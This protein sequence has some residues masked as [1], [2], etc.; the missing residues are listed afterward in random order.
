MVTSKRDI[1][2]DDASIR[3]TPLELERTSGTEVV[4]GHESGKGRGLADVTQPLSALKQTQ[5]NKS[6]GPVSFESGHWYHFHDPLAA[7]NGH[8]IHTIP[9]SYFNTPSHTRLCSCYHCRYFLVLLDLVVHR[10]RL[11]TMANPCARL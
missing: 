1:L 2:L 7:S 4:V 6:F 3:N 9:I 8:F 5:T 11:H 10:I